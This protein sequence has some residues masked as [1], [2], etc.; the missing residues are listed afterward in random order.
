MKKRFLT[1]MVAS[2]VVLML[3]AC[4]NSKE[5][6]SDSVNEKK[7]KVESEVEKDTAKDD[8]NNQEY[9]G[10]GGAPVDGEEPG[11]NTETEVVEPE[12]NTE[13]ETEVVEPE[14]EVVEPV[15]NTITLVD[16]NG[17]VV[18]EG[19]IPAE[20][21]LVDGNG[22][23]HI[24]FA[25]TS[26]PGVSV[27]LDA[28]LDYD[29]ISAM[30]CNAYTIWGG[31]FSSSVINYA[32]SL[33][34]FYNIPEE[35]IGFTENMAY[36]YD[37]WY[38]AIMID[39]IEYRMD[40][41]MLENLIYSEYVN[42]DAGEKV[43]DFFLIHWNRVLGSG[44]MIPI[45]NPDESEFGYLVVKGLLTRSENGLPVSEPPFTISLI[46]E[47]PDV[48]TLTD[49]EIVSNYYNINGYNPLDTSI[50][51]LLQEIVKSF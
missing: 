49:D 16:E 9:S 42:N 12:T 39:D 48:S 7:E 22:T 36:G 15:A 50:P 11:T 40:I 47:Q 27:Y 3:V 28:G 21:T 32:D 23:S 46:V 8:K 31:P 24:E 10:D 43:V 33:I 26:I 35:K 17:T 14:T 37:D 18:F 41:A 19:S 25:Y 20:L 13:P 51:D 1:L 34:S 5:A 6:S 44:D 2:L 45:E 30:K 38:E 29:V 4:G